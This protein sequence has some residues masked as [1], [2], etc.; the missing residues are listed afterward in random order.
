MPEVIIWEKIIQVK[1]NVINISKFLNNIQC[2]SQDNCKNIQLLIPRQN[3]LEV[4]IYTLGLLLI[5]VIQICY[6]T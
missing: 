2:F 5:R 1:Y 3:N 6:V 4:I